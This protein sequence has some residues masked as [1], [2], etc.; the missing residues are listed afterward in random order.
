MSLPNARP[1]DALVD[2]LRNKQLVLVLDNCEHLIGAC[3]ALASSVVERCVGVAILATSREGL[4][5][6]GERMI[7][8]PSLNAPAPGDS[9]DIVAASGSVRLFVDRAV[10]VDAGFVLTAA[11]ADAVA[12]VCRRLDGIPLAI[13]LAAARVP[14]MSLPELVSRLD[15]RFR[16]LAGGRRGA[17]ERHQ[18]LRAAIDWSYELLTRPHQVLLTRM[19]VFVGG[20]TLDAVEVVC[21]ADP[22]DRDDVFDL[23]ADLVARSLVAADHGGP[24]TR[25][26][27]LETIRQ[28]GEERL[29]PDEAEVLR[30]RHG[31]Y[32]AAT[33][34]RLLGSCLRPPAA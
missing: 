4:A 7:A 13:E 10:A 3:A 14:T 25:Y 22:V 17:V 1:E 29:D 21:S 8:V 34:R 18:T 9:L 23:L 15:R 11:N 20:C 19:S 24:V 2:F 33:R 16:I 28:Y 30:G 5:V 6:A 12:T 31:E 32:Y 27:L 26:R